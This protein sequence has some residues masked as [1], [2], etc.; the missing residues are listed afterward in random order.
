[1]T[2]PPPTA[3]HRARDPG[4]RLGELGRVTWVHCPKCD[5]AARSSGNGVE[6]RHCGYVTIQREARE[7]SWARLAADKPLCSFCRK[8]LPTAPLPTR[9]EVEGRL[10]VRVQCPHCR[11]TVDYPA[12]P[13]WPPT[14]EAPLRLRLY[15]VAKVAGEDLWIENLAHLAALEDYLGALVR[16]R[17]PEGGL[18]MMA[19]LPA[20]MKSAHNRPKI[21]RA[22][23]QL[24]ERAAKAGIDE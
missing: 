10:M 23:G 3:H 4:V 22:L 5:Q 1:V 16:E 15:L 11:K 17:A 18:T 2:K 8:D 19:R 21:L 14:D 12:V 6:C 24:R 20:W 7:N 9:R 13:A